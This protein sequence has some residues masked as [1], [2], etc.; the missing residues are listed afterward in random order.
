VDIELDSNDGTLAVSVNSSGAL[1]DTERSALAKLADGFQQAINGLSASPPE[2]DLSGLTQYD[3]S[4]L[5][6]VNLQFN[7]TGD[8]SNYVS[9][10]IALNSS[11][12]SVKL[13][14]SDGTINLS[15]DTSD[16]A[17]L[18]QVR[19][20]TRPSQA[21]WRSSTTPTRRPRKQRADVHIQRRFHADEQQRWDF[22]A[23][24]SRYSLH[25][26]AR[27]SRARHVDG[28]GRFHRLDYRQHGVI[29]SI[30]AEPNG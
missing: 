27:A 28:S 22:V 15:V 13:T 11:T 10:Y 24:A 20:R 19:N 1:S 25:A 14:D 18:V 29:Q 12:R 30:A 7:V 23:T 16:S 26:V 8:G 6:S 17:I 9:A 21:I 2:L 4:V 5:S 3:T